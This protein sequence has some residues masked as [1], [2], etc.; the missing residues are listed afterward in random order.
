MKILIL[1]TWYYPDTT[2]A[3]KRPYYFAKYLS[4]FGHDVTVIRSGLVDKAIDK[5][6]DNYKQ[7]VW[8]LSYMGEDCAL[9]R[10][11]RGEKV[12]LEGDQESRLSFLP[13]RLAKFI[14]SVYH[15]FFRS[16]F[17]FSGY[18]AA[19][20]RFEKLKKC[21]YKLNEAG[22][23]FD[24]AFSTFG[25]IENVWVGK[26]CKELFHCPWIL[27]FRDHLVS[28]W[29]GRKGRKI[30]FKQEKENICF[31]DAC[32]TVSFDLTATLLG[33]YSN[34]NIFTIQNG[35]DNDNLIK[36]KTNDKKLSFIYTGTL[37]SGQDLSPL[38]QAINQ[39]EN[40][41][42]V[43]RKKILLNYAGNDFDHLFNQAKKYK[44]E[45]ILVNHGYVSREK[46]FELQ[47]NSDIFVVAS[48]NTR[49]EKG[50][51][52][53]KFYEGIQAKKPILSLVSGKEPNSELFVLN[54]KYAYG[55]CYEQS[56]DKKSFNGL[57]N[58]LAEKY[59]EKMTSGKI[60]HQPKK[61]LFEDF[62]YE[63]LTKKLEKIMLD[64]VLIRK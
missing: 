28:S 14:S 29:V 59:A 34:I 39:L 15:K 49:D 8:I 22:E 36:S 31:A 25:E 40:K 1:T 20:E 10:Y 30:L 13:K 27:D 42:K 56:N 18:K 4:E 19:Q 64:S 55:Y 24:V 61:E 47:A 54:E 48:W 51:V 44:L 11:E 17:F 26:V 62:K 38:F 52:T 32:T 43:D 21:L 2:I 23:T 63:N 35:F 53:G 58:F 5:N 12:L 6:L 37:Y 33:R 45:D 46:S 60:T 16:S 7:S 50:I 57:M 3:A 9:E 41:K